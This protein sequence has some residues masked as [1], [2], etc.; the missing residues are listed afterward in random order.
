[1]IAVLKDSAVHRANFPTVGL[2]EDIAGRVRF[3]SSDDAE[4]LVLN[5]EGLCHILSGMIVALFKWRKI[6]SGKDEILDVVS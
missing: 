3:T 5:E 4:G 2:R 6:D 1:V